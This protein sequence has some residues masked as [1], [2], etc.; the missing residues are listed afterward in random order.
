AQISPLAPGPSNRA[1]STLLY[2]SA[3]DRFLLLFGYDGANPS[4][5]VWELKLAPAP[6]WRLLAP[7][8]TPPSARA[9]LRSAYVPCQDHVIA[10]GGV[11]FHELWAVDFATASDG[12]WAPIATPTHPSARASGQLRLD[13]MRN[14]LLLFGGFGEQAQPDN[15]PL[16]TSLNDTWALDLNGSP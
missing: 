13:T 15:T 6:T 7:S 10:F 14:R 1:H 3:R 16:I 12:T 2:D 4:N 5:D 9:D 11:G 8:G